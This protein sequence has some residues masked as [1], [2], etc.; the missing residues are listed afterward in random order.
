MAPKKSMSSDISEFD[1]QYRNGQKEYSDSIPE[2]PEKTSEIIKDVLLKYGF[3]SFKNGFLWI[4]DPL[5]MKEYYQLWFENLANREEF[6]NSQETFPFMR[7]AFGGVFYFYGEELG[8]I[9]V[10]TNNSNN[11]TMGY[12]FNRTLVDDDHLR[13][14]Y[15]HDLFKIAL[16]RFGELESD[17]CYA[18]L[19][20]L[21]LGG[22]IDEAHL[23]KVKLREHLAL[24]SSLLED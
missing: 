6:I 24:L 11:L 14:I 15:F 5:Q 7:T 20:P 16:E 19:P 3:S 10:I 23:Q 2:F 21:A 4:L 18:F 17:E 22:E 12:Y 8:Y 1:A 9:S 13:N